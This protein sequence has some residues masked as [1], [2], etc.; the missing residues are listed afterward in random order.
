MNI[1][2]TLLLVLVLA[3]ASIGLTLTGC[4]EKNEPASSGGEVKTCC[5]D[6]PTQCCASEAAKAVKEA[7]KECCGDDPTK[8]CASKATEEHPTGE[9]PQ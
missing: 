1:R 7:A 8:C 4:E 5:G 3:I 6:D 9:H 2:K